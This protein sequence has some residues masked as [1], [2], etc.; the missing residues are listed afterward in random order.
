MFIGGV[1][2]KADSAEDNNLQIYAHSALNNKHLKY[3]DRSRGISNKGT[4]H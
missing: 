1:V 2:V 4:T 3:I